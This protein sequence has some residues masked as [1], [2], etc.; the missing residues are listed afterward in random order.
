MLIC[1]QN[2]QRTLELGEE[3]NNIHEK[4]LFEEDNFLKKTS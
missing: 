4:C 3:N 2:F 1:L